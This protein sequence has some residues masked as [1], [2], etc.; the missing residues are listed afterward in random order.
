MK[1][2]FTLALLLFIISQADA[3]RTSG[4]VNSDN[5]TVEDFG[6]QRSSG[7]S[8][9]G[10]GI[11]G[12]PQRFVIKN[13]SQIEITPSY[14]P[15]L[16]IFILNGEVEEFDYNHGVSVMAGY[17]I[18]LSGRKK[19]YKKKTA[20]QY[21]SAKSGYWFSDVDILTFAVSWRKE[22]FKY[23][24]PHRSFGFDLGLM[25]GRV[26]GDDFINEVNGNFTKNVAGVFF[27]IDWNYYKK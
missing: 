14:S 21:I 2:L 12:F 16:N 20:K 3:Q 10:N 24:N 7:I 26:L 5:L 15:R 4:Q 23:K 6:K 19:D 27:K 25:V 13:K 1:Q 17:N 11:V 9:L 18:Y 22:A 8:L